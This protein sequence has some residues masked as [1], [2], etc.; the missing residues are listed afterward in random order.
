MNRPDRIFIARHGETVFNA[1]R[2]L[3]GTRPHTPLTRAGFAQA[4]A[5]GR[6][7]S[8]VIDRQRRLALWASDTGRALQTLAIITEHLECDWHEART[9]A[10]LGEIAMGDWGGRYYS[11]V[12][13]AHGPI[14]DHDQ[15][16]FVVRPPDGEWYDDIARRLQDWLDD[17]AQ[18]GGDLLI[19]SHGIT[20]RVLR[21]MLTGLACD[22]ILRAP[23]A[24][25]LPQGSMVMIEEGVERVIAMGAGLAPA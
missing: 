3:Q 13:G 22:P 5:M 20:S 12:E 17:H 6:A 10:R 8:G 16:L 15:G 25:A 2:R 7:L 24:P 14:I 4:E 23:V 18:D 21:G 11:D 1:V 19:I 9:D